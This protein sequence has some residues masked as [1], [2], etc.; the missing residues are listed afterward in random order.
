MSMSREG[1]AMPTP[2]PIRAISGR[3]LIDPSSSEARIRAITADM[4]MLQAMTRS[5]LV[6][7]LATQPPAR[8]PAV[9]P[10]M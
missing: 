2:S 4:V 5:L 3:T 1:V 7:A 9:D 10:K 6:K 8:I